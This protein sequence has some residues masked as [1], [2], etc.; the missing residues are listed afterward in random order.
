MLETEAEACRQVEDERG[1]GPGLLAEAL[2]VCVNTSRGR[3]R[4]VANSGEQLGGGM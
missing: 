3:L 4:G 1:D 2:Q